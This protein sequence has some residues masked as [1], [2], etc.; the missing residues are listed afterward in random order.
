MSGDVPTRTARRR[1]RRAAGLPPAA[2]AESRPGEEAASSRRIR[3]VGAG[4]ASASTRGEAAADDLLALAGGEGPPGIAELLAMPVV[5]D[6]RPIHPLRR[7]IEARTTIAKGARLLG[8][9]ERSLREVLAWRARFPP[10]KERWFARWLGVDVDELFPR[11][12]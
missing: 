4:P 7:I 8:V 2:L 10:A 9:S 11:L 1:A 6:I 3:G 12:P 5:R